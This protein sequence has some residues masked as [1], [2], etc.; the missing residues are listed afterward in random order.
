MSHTGQLLDYLA[1]QE[2]AVLIYHASDMILAAHSDASYLSEPNGCSR[3]GSHFFLS[4]NA[5]IPPNNDTILNLAHIIKHVMASATEAKLA[6]LYITA[7]EAIYIQIILSELGHK[8]PLHHLQ[9]DN[10][11]ADAVVM[12]KSNQNILKPWTCGSTG[13]VMATAKNNSAFI[14]TWVKTTMP[15]IGPNITQPNIISTSEVNVSLH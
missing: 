3:A 2:E 14:G 1:T 10:A 9:T 4:S 13:Y 5:D 7:H 15:T 6:A 8:N 11:M 12:A